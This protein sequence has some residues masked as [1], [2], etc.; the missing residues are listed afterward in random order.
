M[1][2]DSETRALYAI[3]VELTGRD[4]GHDAVSYHFRRWIKRGNTPH[5]LRILIRWVKHRLKREEVT[6][7]ALHLGRLLDPERAAEHLADAKA[8]IASH[9]RRRPVDPVRRVN[10]PPSAPDGDALSEAEMRHVADE[11]RKWREAQD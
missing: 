5:D 10:L 2:L 4:P 7:S 6:T 9:R 11:I 8:Y 1:E 3:Y